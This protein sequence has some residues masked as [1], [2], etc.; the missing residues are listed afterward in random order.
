MASGYYVRIR[1]YY[2]TRAVLHNDIKNRAYALSRSPRFPRAC[3]KSHSS[4]RGVYYILPAGSEDGRANSPLLLHFFLLIPY[5]LLMFQS[6]FR[7]S[8][9][10]LNV[11][12]VFFSMFF[13]SLSKIVANFPKA[14]LSNL[15]RNVK[16]TRMLA[17]S[18]RST[19][20]KFV[21]CPTC[22]SLR[23]A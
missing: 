2:S 18:T 1:T 19:L 13:S 14:F 11:L 5:F 7:L 21:C 23:N 16:C 4:A 12:L 8:D 15:P 10:A 22:H 20:R 3:F 6:L 9:N 17:G